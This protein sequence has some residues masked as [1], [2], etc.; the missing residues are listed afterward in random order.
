M[1]AGFH[2]ISSGWMLIDDFDDLTDRIERLAVW[3]AANEPLQPDEWATIEL[4][5]KSQIAR[6]IERGDFN[7][8]VHVK[9]AE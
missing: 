9:K 8:V 3:T 5:I 7:F 2:E 6:G 1:R 4:M